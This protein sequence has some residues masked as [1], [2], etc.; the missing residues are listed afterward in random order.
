MISH[1]VTGRRDRPDGTRR[2]SSSNSGETETPSKIIK[3][4]HEVGTLR[5]PFSPTIS[6]LPLPLPAMAQQSGHLKKLHAK[7]FRGQSTDD[8]EDGKPVRSSTDRNLNINIPNPVLTDSSQNGPVPPKMTKTD[9]NTTNRD[10]ED[11][12]GRPFRV[13]L[14][15]KLGP[16]YHGT[17]RFRLEQDDKRERHW[18]RWGPY[19][20]DR[21][22][23]RGPPFRSDSALIDAHIGY[24]PRGLLCERG[25]LEPL[26]S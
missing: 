18:K 6:S 15:D 17:E 23:V 13:R 16:D 11:V 25:C 21:Q 26:S 19:L 4:L 22:W 20:S 3:G 7:I 5:P 10:D 8:K 14:A 1:D 12:D 9:T 2:V 24:R